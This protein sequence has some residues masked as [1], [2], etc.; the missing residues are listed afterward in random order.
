MILH[1]IL[2][3]LCAAPERPAVISP[4]GVC[5]YGMLARQICALQ[6]LLAPYRGQR[7]LVYDRK[8]SRMLANM[9]ACAFAGV[10]YIPADTSYPAPRVEKMAELAAPALV[11]TDLPLELPGVRRVEQWQIDALPV[12]TEPL[13]VQAQET[14]TAYILFTSGSTGTPKGVKV[15]W[16]SLTGF[17]RW[18]RTLVGFNPARVL[19]QAA[20]S[21]DLSVADILLT[22]TGGGALVLTPPVRQGFPALFSFFQTCQAEAAVMTP[23]FAEML[24][25]D[26]GFGSSL[27]PKLRLIF[28]CGEQLRPNTVLR[29]RQRFENL[30]IINAY[31]PTEA[32][33]AV[34]AHE[35]AEA[36]DPYA[37]L[38]AGTPVPG[39]QVAIVDAALHPLPPEQEGE[40]LLVGDAVAQGYV[41]GV[42]GGFCTYNGQKAYRTGDLGRLRDGELFVSG[43]TDDQLKLRGYRVEP[44]EIEVQLCA[45]PGVA[46]AVVVPR[47]SA[48]GTVQRLVAFVR[49]EPGFDPVQVHKELARRLPDYM[50]PVIRAV[51]TLKRNQN[52]KYDRKALEAMLYER[53]TD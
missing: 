48:D 31:G 39:T 24:L 12:S 10:T 44:G 23:S 30:R 40:I 16:S 21:F 9:L 1:T 28:F 19:N 5:T 36:I 27:L 42:C 6:P 52:G 38:P 17:G 11:F 53:G 26:K 43:R 34:T 25:S 20:F 35:L 45:L 4:D 46:E 2:S 32:T 37:P 50:C 8:S 15:S 41:G 22:L 14:D 7:A 13:M 47:R 49:P 51:Q 3:V 33:V 18:I 29:L